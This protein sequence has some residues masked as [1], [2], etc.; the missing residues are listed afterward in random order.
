MIT[1][2]ESRKPAPPSRALPTLVPV[3]LVALALF[4]AVAQQTFVIA[5]ARSDLVAAAARQERAYNQ[6]LN[7]RN[8]LEAIATDTVK[9]AGDGDPAAKAITEALKSE[10]IIL[11]QAK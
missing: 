8:Q 9:L 4:V 7:F 11:P 1:G 3:A 5:G 2:L 6:A 10:G